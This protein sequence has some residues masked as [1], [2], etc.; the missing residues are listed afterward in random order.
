MDDYNFPDITDRLVLDPS[1]FVHLQAYVCGTITLGAE[2]SVWPM[3]VIRGDEGVIVIGDRT[4]I[5]DGCVLHADPDAYLTIGNDVTLGHGALVHGCTIEDNVL[6]GIGA[7]V[8][9][10]AVIGTGSIIGARALVT[11]G[12]VVPPGSLV[13]GVPGKIRP[14]R[15]EQQERISLPAKHYVALQRLHRERERG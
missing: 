2:S 7:V 14:L 9:N 15:P 5:Q 6:I 10:H 3:A 4:N 11:E 1:A 13:M 8:L 12:M